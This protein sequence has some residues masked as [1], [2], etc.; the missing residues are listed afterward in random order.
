VPPTPRWLVPAEPAEPADWVG[1]GACALF[2]ADWEA[3]PK[4]PPFVRSDGSG[5][6]EQQTV[7]RICASAER[8]YVRFDCED[9]DI[10]ATLTNRDDP[11]Y[12]EEVVEIFIAPGED[13]PCDYF[14]FEV[15][16]NG[17][18]F[19]AT[20][21]NP[22]ANR[23][24]MTADPAWNCEGIDWAA[25]RFDS[26]GRWE[27]ILVMP[28]AGVSEWH[29]RC[30]RANFFRIERPRDGEAEYSCW[31]PTLVMPADFHKPACFG[32]LEIEALPAE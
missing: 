3:V 8:L 14:E 13:E 23:F 26:E 27:A 6:A 9:R 11:I 18:L 12:D 16:P 4:L 5:S 2:D 15:S 32:T 31:S 19:D 1:L 7:A 25:R 17:V 20:I 22:D 28:W 30:W 24:T 10:W 21:H 29:P